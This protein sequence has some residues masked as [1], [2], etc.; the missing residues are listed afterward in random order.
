V[1]VVCVKETFVYEDF[2]R[3]NSFVHSICDVLAIGIYI[4]FS[5]H[6]C[7]AYTFALQNPWIHN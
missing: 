5:F 4:I 3:L 7:V 2:H 6:F 1:V